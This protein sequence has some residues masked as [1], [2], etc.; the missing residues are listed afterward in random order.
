MVIKLY[1]GTYTPK[2]RFL[3]FFEYSEWSK[4][5]RVFSLYM[6]DY[7]ATHP[8]AKIRFRAS[9]MVLN[10]HSDTSYLS[11]AK[12]RSRAGGYFF[13]GSFPTDGKPIQLNGNIMITCKILKLVASS[14]AE[15]ELGA[16]FV[17]TK[18]AKIIRLTLQELGHLQPQMPIH[19]DNTTVIGIVNNTIKQQRSRT[20]EMRY[21]WL[22]STQKK[23]KYSV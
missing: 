16:L 20:M 23:P 13:L 6:H 2:P 1:S 18:E 12:C 14:A 4:N 3:F 10:V 8:E 15:A 11:A 7:M 21:F 22:L 17:S 19:V 9:D 5:H